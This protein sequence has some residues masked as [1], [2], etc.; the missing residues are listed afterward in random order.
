M[1]GVKINSAKISRLEIDITP[2]IMRKKGNF[3]LKPTATAKPI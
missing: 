1:G 3:S 2:T